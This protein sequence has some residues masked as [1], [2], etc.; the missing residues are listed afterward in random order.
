MATLEKIRQKQALLF[1]FI[2]VALLAFILGD[3]LTG[4]NRM[5]A[6]SSAAA[7]VDG[8]TVN[9]NDLETNVKQQTEAMQAQGYTKVDNARVQSQ[10]LENML[11]EGLM[12]KELDALGIVVT[13]KELSVAMT[14]GS[15]L[16]MVMQTVQ[17][18]GL[19]TPEQLYDCAYNPAK[20]G[21]PQ[22]MASQ[23]AAAWVDLEKQV[24][25]Q[26]KAMKFGNLF[27]GA[28]TANKLDAKAFYEENATT[29]TIEYVR[30][31]LATLSND[32]Y[33]PTVAEIKAKYDDNK[34]RYRL[35]APVRKVDYITVDIVPS[36]EDL[37]AAQNDV[38]TALAALNSTEGVGN[39]DSRFYVKTAET[40]KA[41]MRSEDLKKKIDEVEIGEAFQLSFINNNYTLIKLLGVNKNQQDS[42]NVD[43]AIANVNSAAERDSIL[44][45]L[46]DGAKFEDIANIADSSKDNNIPLLDPSA[47]AFKQ[48]IADAKVGKYFT[49]DTA[50]TATQVRI[51]RINRFSPLVT[52]YNI[53][54]ITYEV[55][56]SVQ[57]RNE[58]N[59]KLREYI[60]KNSTA[61]DFAK[62]A[63][64][65]GYRIFP[66]EVYPSSLS[67]ANIENTISAAKWVL[68]AKVGQVSN[69][70]GGDTD[71]LIAVALKAAYEDGFT[72]VSD[73][74]LKEYVTSEARNDKK[75]DKLIKDFEGKGNTIAE[76]AGV[77]NASV[78]T[79]NVAFGQ[80][81]YMGFGMNESELAARV[82]SAKT[83]DLV[84][85][86]KTNNA[87]VVIKVNAVEKTGR[88]FDFDT[89][90]AAFNR[91]QGAQLIGR[92]LYRIL[93]G[94]NEV[95]YHILERYR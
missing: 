60:L 95:E 25:E 12:N 72:P 62:N 58:L 89:D 17:S 27:S 54:E 2:I 93:L 34:N 28:L 19:Q 20:M 48:L 13:G 50:A 41:A 68:D 51:F 69:I 57:T 59:G 73:P 52:T 55:T 53:A 9:Y 92:N 70:F 23:F 10:V 71:R 26:L 36:Q 87:V 43:Y 7:E 81:M 88:E 44:N 22:E 11:Y 31:D 77:M 65:A 42:V 21:I 6:P 38:E 84:G 3:Y 83:G 75:A 16:P 24:E 82:A 78:D 46:N 79:T 8:V 63:A 14:S 61:E 45:L 91:Q 47:A 85:P 80:R 33:E 66:A 5:S 94:N 67:V 64:E 40:S 1:T 56:P 15:G 37:D 35:D 86:F 4:S 29:S 39:I 18:Y 49:P 32:E 90:A 76:Y 74:M 30:V